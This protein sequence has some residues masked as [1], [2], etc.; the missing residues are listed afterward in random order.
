[1]RELPKELTAELLSLVINKKIKKINNSTIDG[2]VYYW[3]EFSKCKSK[4]NIDTL[5][6]L[7]IEKIRECN[8]IFNIF[9]STS[10]Q[11]FGGSIGNGGHSKKLVS[12][13]MFDMALEAFHW[14]A[15]EK[16][17]I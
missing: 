17:L 9:T 14:V 5:T 12:G 13:T 16:G 10:L 8:Y 11:G 15:K 2:N 3:N 7:I 1:M 4:L 6:R